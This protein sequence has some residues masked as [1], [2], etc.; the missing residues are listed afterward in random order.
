MGALPEDYKPTRGKN[1]RSRADKI[2]CNYHLCRKKLPLKKCKYCGGYY[3]SEHH[4]AKP[5][6]LP[7]FKGADN[8][9]MQMYRSD[10]GHPC[11]PYVDYLAEK[12][13][14]DREKYNEKLGEILGDK[15]NHGKG[16]IKP[17]PTPK[18]DKD[19]KTGEEGTNEG[20]KGR[21]GGTTSD[22]I[23]KRNR[24]WT[25]QV[26]RTIGVIIFLLVLYF[27]WIKP[28]IDES[29]IT[30]HCTELIQEK[31]ST[32]GLGGTVYG[33]RIINTKYYKDLESAKQSVM[34][35]S[36]IDNYES[37]SVR[38]EKAEYPILLINR[39][40]FSDGEKTEGTS[41][42]DKN[43]IIRLDGSYV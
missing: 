7:N 23:P 28:F 36:S 16:I 12:K 37:L 3:C 10:E 25:K 29:A 42:C 1:G 41:I 33:V 5:P 9:L 14:K 4:Q 22:P 27:F 19:G 39:E 40:V 2:K 20:S 43:G 35:G 15:K 8:E 32:G 17:T 38:L 13:K 21:P 6:V 30:T 26:M 31:A 24:N 11:P 34:S 18:K